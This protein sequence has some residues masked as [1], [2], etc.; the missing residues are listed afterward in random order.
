M[1]NIKKFWIITFCTMV[2]VSVFYVPYHIE[3]PS[4]HGEKFMGYGSLFTHTVNSGH[5]NN[6]KPFDDPKALLD[7]IHLQE[8]MTID[9]KKIII[10]IIGAAAACSIGYIISTMF[11]KQNKK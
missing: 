7:E 9:Y 5:I 11:I 4:G 8:K 6:S 10:E 2:A 1:N 3:Y